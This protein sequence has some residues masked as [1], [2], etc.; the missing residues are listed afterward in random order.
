MQIVD[1]FAFPKLKFSLRVLECINQ[2][3]VIHEIIIFTRRLCK[4]EGSAINDIPWV[5]EPGREYFH[6]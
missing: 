5:T 6:H 1:D 3:Y 4:I 2:L